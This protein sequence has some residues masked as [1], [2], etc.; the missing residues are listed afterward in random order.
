MGKLRWSVGRAV[1]RLRPLDPK[2]LLFAGEAHDPGGNLLPL[3]QRLEQ[4]G[5][6]CECLEPKG[7]ALR[8]MGYARGIF[9]AGEFAPAA[10][11]QP[12]RG[13]ALV[14][15]WDHCG[16]LK[17][18]GGALD[19]KAPRQY[20][21]HV[22]VSAPALV[23]PFAQA[24]CC[25]EG[26]VQ[27]W[28]APRTDCYA[29]PEFCAESRQRVREAFPEIA[30]RSILLYAPEV[31]GPLDLAAMEE[32]LGEDCALLLT[33]EPEV[34]QENFAF[35]AGALPPEVLLA[36]AELAIFD[37]SP[38]MFEYA[39]LGRPMLFYPHDLE[40]QEQVPGFFWPYLGLVP[41]D[42]VWDSEDVI[43]GIRHN[44]SGGFDPLRVERFRVNYMAACDGQAVERIL[45]KVLNAV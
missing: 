44:L 41:G 37:Y 22:C 29:R 40:E 38:L 23:R 27:P 9:L 12:R 31:G 14:Q 2:L 42:L 6:R 28:G 26:A 4:E 25:G 7:N 5:Y 11:Y 10:G 36:A 18:W 43:Q 19:E 24:L 8:R 15:L 1:G 17:R 21:T 35:Y 30:G 3:R 20:Y 32:A 33:K 13:Q 45:W 39:L 34:P 16:A